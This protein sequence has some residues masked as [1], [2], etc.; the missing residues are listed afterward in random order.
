MQLN[1]GKRFINKESDKMDINTVLEELK[2]VLK[3]KETKKISRIKN[4]E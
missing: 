4:E 2:K 1:T 3:E